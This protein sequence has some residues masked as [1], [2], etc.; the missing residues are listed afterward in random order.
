M[1][2]LSLISKAQGVH[3]GLK[4]G[5]RRRVGW[6]SS[7]GFHRPLMV[8]SQ[9]PQIPELPFGTAESMVALVRVRRPLTRQLLD[10]GYSNGEIA[11]LTRLG[12]LQ[13]IR[14]GA[15]DSPSSDPI[16][17]IESHRRLIH[18]SKSYL[19]RGSVVSHASRRF[20]M[21]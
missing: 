21:V 9:H 6:H 15:Y 20:F 18:A 3:A 10:E 13:R 7:A 12:A 11:R 14:R 16:N 8:L 17:G 4:V 2:T 5:R 1:S 19:A